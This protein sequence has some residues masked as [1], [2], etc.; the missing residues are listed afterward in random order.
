M[1]D[2]DPVIEI[3]EE[4]QVVT[5]VVIAAG[6]PGPRGSGDGP[7]GPA[8]PQGIQ[9][10]QGPKGDT[11]AA[12]AKGDQGNTGADGAIVTDGDI[13][14]GTGAPSDGLGNDGDIYINDANNDLYEKVSGHWTLR[15]NIKGQKGDKGDKGDT[16]DAGAGGAQ[17]IQGIQG[18]P[19]TTGADGK[20]ILT[21]NSAPSNGAGNNGDVY[22]N[23]ANGDLYDKVGGVWMF[24]LNLVGPEGP[25]GDTGT[26]GSL[27]RVGSG[28][29]SDALGVNGDVYI[30]ADEGDLYLKAGGTY[31]LP[32]AN[33]TGAAGSDGDDG[34]PGA[35][36]SPGATWR[37][38]SGAPSNGTG[39][40]GDL[41]LN[42]DNGDVYKRGPSVYS[43]IAN[44]IGPQ[45]NPGDDG[46]DGTNGTVWRSGAGAPDN[47]VGLDGDFYLRTSNGVV[48]LRSAGAYA[49][50]ITIKGTDGTNGTNGS[51]GTNGATWSSGTAVP[52]GGN[53]G[54][55][56]L[57]TTTNDVYK[58]TAGTW[59][60]VAALNSRGAPVKYT[61]S[62][63]ALIGDNTNV[64]EME[65]ASA[66]TYTIP[67]H[68][69]VAFPVGAQMDLVQT[70]AGLTTIVAGAGVTIHS[71]NNALKMSAQWAGATI[72]QRAQD[73]WVLTGNI[74][75]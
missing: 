38:G 39:I 75:T 26:A 11:G 40:E 70:G 51:N 24:R 59:A 31:G 54:D 35:D 21:G 66:N 49:A 60:V 18:T 53:S 1:A 65:S 44:I 63:I 62:Q 68:S 69:S 7:Q 25:Q 37:T 72:Y 46:D 23:R 22:I 42:N 6:P 19:G 10:I 48:Y 55:F 14:F 32:Q 5:V 16:G 2:G 61:A 17:G 28:V 13:L 27:I 50:A 30:N 57:R 3:V 67:P 29:P 9:G 45:G 41:Y 20:T 12:G 43:V 74:T 15:T 73:E 47:A 64:V 33:L 52:T 34:A 36:G 71:A 56:Y 4:G 8:G 58:N